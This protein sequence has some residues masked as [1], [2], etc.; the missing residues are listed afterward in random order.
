MADGKL[1]FLCVGAGRDGTSTVAAQINEVLRSSG[2]GGECVHEMHSRDLYEL[3]CDL[4]ERPECTDTQ[5]RIRQ[6]IGSFPCVAASG[7]GYAGVL[8]IFAELYPT[9]KLIHLRR[10]DK[11]AFISSQI[12]NS[13]LFPDTYVYYST[14]TGVMRRIAA[15]HT[16][17]A[18]R[19]QWSAFSLAEKF[20][21]FYEYTHRL[22]A[23]AYSLFP[24]VLEIDTEDLSNPE[25][26]RSLAS[27]VSGDASNAPGPRRLNSHNLI[28]VFDFPAKQRPFAQWLFGRLNCQQVAEEN[29]VLVDHVLNSTIAWLGFLQTG[30]ASQLNEQYSKPDEEVERLAQEVLSRVNFYGDE[31][32]RFISERF[33]PGDAI[34]APHPRRLNGHKLI[35]LSDFPAEQ[36]AFAQWLFGRLN[37]QQ[38]APD[39]TVLMDHVMDSTISWLGY[40]QT[41]FASQLD[42]HYSKPHAEVK[43]LA[44]EVLSRLN[45]Y[46]AEIARFIS[47]MDAPSSPP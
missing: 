40:L 23:S 7:N 46:S 18:T 21:W 38:I 28:D 24:T 9:L 6:L 32:A 43:R 8:P 47:E 33:V 13:Q 35:D 26:L 25:T 30:V 5:K 39:N 45:F 14:D 27:F 36:R 41:G 34:N 20:D 16:G 44:Q 19:D 1:Q 11:Q 29:T 15:F 17:E 22:V 42:E 4:I 3:Q 2:I 12:R 31:I 10:R 37:S